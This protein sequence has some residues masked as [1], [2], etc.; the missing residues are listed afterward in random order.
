MAIGARWVASGI[1]PVGPMLAAAFCPTFLGAW[2]D[3]ADGIA[4][5]ASRQTYP[6]LHVL[7]PYA[8]FGSRRLAALAFSCAISA[9]TC[10]VTH[11]GS[12]DLQAAEQG[13]SGIR[14][15]PAPA[16]EPRYRCADHCSNDSTA[17]NFVVVDMMPSCTGSQFLSRACPRANGVLVLESDVI[18]RELSMHQGFPYSFAC[19]GRLTA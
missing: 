13:H 2:P 11:T 8:P 15:P 9:A 7:G 10:L 12:S 19:A 3:D 18:E 4:L 6:D 16:R 14:R 5:K 1:P 17:P